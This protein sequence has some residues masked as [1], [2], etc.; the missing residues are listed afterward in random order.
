MIKPVKFD[1]KSSEGRWANYVFTS[2]D[3]NKDGKLTEEEWKSSQRTRRSFEKYKVQPTFPTDKKSFSG[4]IVA[5]M[6]E[7]KKR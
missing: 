4:W 6:R 3:R 5:V 1:E 2:L 7:E